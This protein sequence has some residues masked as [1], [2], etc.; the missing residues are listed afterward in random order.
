MGFGLG[1]LIGEWMTRNL[2]PDADHDEQATK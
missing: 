1:A 2:P